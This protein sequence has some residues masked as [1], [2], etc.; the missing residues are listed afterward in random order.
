MLKTINE[1]KVFIIV[2]FGQLFSLTG[3]NLTGF[4]LGV[5][6]FQLT[7][8]ATQFALISLS[9]MLPGIL[10]SPIAGA[11]IDRW[12]RRWVMIVSDIGAAVCTVGLFI[13]A[14][15]LKIWHIYLATALISICNAFQQP[16]YLAS[17]TMLVPKQN[18]SRANGMMQLGEAI[19]LLISPILGGL[20]LVAIQL[21]GILL[22]DLT[23]FAIAVLTL[24][25]VKFPNVAVT[26]E[27]NSLFQD[28]L[29]GWHY[30]ILRPGLLGLLALFAVS[31]F[32][33][34]IVGVL[35]TPLILS[36]SSAVALG[37]ILSIGGIG[38]L[39]GSLV[40]SI[41]GGPKRLVHGVLGF[42]LL[43]GIWI[44]VAG[45]DNNVTTLAISAFLFFF[46]LPII[47]GCS[48]TILQ[49]KVKPEIQGRVFA[50]GRM[51]AWSTLPLAYIIAGPLADY[52]FEPL[53]ANNGYLA[54]S[55]GQII[56]VG[57]GR[58]IGLLFIIFGILNILVTIIFYYYPR[59]RLL[60]DELPD[61]IE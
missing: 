42:Q 40:M 32:L 21:S 3:S 55:I 28:A 48:H 12:D 59:L 31:N 56:G 44:I 61:F 26:T 57:S 22:L 5:W 9:V 43:S 49:K 2:W 4:A 23:T 7:G 15:E 53:M 52:I 24:L 14:N 41:W 45:L 11:L 25:L 19:P 58:G 34:G 6:V 54:N 13:I 51:L 47:N 27:K 1:M 29:S 16:A 8:S 18:L 36:F 30:L 50:M 38:M 60:E 10:I 20:L 46:G 39:V 17:V 37:S 33:T 35:I